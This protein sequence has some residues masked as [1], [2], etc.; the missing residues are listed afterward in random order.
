MM[1]ANFVE[2]KGHRY[3]IEALGLLPGPPAAVTCDLAGSGEL[4][5]E[6]RGL[7]AAAGVGN[8]VNFLGMVPHHE[9]LA[10]LRDGRWQAVVLPSVETAQGEKE[11]IP[12]ALME[13][14]A[15]GVPAV[16]TTTGAIAE[17]LE[18]GAGV[19]VPPRDPRALAAALQELA[20]HPALRAQLARAGRRRIEEAYEIGAVVGQLEAAF[21]A[22]VPP[23]ARHARGCPP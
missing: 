6:I 12:V 10:G 19:L 18:E 2:K 8:R 7:V 21:A 16:S 20:E 23:A 9:L 13:A 11:G 17:L 4:E 22:A 3:L 1:P 5:D 15:A 14:L